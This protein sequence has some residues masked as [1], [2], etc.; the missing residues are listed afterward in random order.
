M[1]EVGTVVK[2]YTFIRGLPG[3]NLSR[4]AVCS[5]YVFRVSVLTRIIFV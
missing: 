2:S 5:V 4:A 1:V 3:L